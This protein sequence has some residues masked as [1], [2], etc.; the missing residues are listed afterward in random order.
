MMIPRTLLITAAALVFLGG[1]AAA[2]PLR[3]AD[4][5]KADPSQ[6]AAKPAKEPEKVRTLIFG[7]GD[8]VEGGVLTPEGDV[9]QGRVDVPRSSLI[10]LRTHF[11]PEI[12]KSA[13]LVL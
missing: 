12:Y 3:V 5:G 2:S 8:E 1:S 7:E 11:L 4:A 6:P 9:M 10:R 13:E